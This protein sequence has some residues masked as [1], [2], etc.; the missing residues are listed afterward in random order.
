MIFHSSDITEKWDGHAN[1]GKDIAQQDVYVYLVELLD[2]RGN[3]HK[4]RGTVTLVR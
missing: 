1:Y 3:I 2:F 4:Y